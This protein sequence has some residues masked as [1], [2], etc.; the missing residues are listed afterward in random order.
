MKV[1]SVTA[2]GAGM[3]CGSCKHDNLLA[4]ELMRRGVDVQLVPTFT[5]IR[6]DDDDVSL[7]RVFLGGL[8]LYLQDRWPALRRLPPWLDRW[9]AHPA[10]LRALSRSGLESQAADRQRDETR[11]ALTLLAGLAGSLAKETAVLV[12]WIVA[13]K[14][15]IVHVSNLLVAGFVPELQRRLDVPV[16]ATLQG[17]DLFLD[18]LGPDGRVQVLDG[19]RRLAASVDAF[20]VTS[21]YYRDHMSALLELE[22]ERVHVHPLG[23]DPEPLSSMDSPGEPSDQPPTIGYLARLWEPKGLGLLVDAFLQLV[24]RVD[25][26]ELRVAGWLGA[27][28]RPFVEAQRRRL[29]AVGL[30]DRFHLETDVDLAGKVR[31]LRSIDLL[32]VPTLYPESKGMYALEAMAAGVP[33]VLPRHGALP[34]LLDR[35]GGGVLVEPNDAAA[36]AEALSELLSDDTR[37]HALGA[38]G[39]AGVLKGATASHAA[40]ALFELYDRL[41]KRESNQESPTA[42]A[43]SV[44]NEIANP[45]QKIRG[46]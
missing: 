26:V 29:E 15:D 41:V 42:N 39:R 22:T 23:I 30:G 37:R 20:V 32:C 27:A 2:G 31:F 38:D 9:L 17:D 36:L 1:V 33:V 14:P 21:R 12:D 43:A 5:P 11:L 45:I 16:V 44:N 8:H 10:L 24:E 4:R 7:P 19:L 34:E 46:T 6:T 3:Y 25:G 40:E 13:E 28:D 35:T 18:E